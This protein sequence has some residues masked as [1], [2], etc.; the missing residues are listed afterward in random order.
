LIAKLQE[1]LASPLAAIF[2][3]LLHLANGL[4]AD[5]S[6]KT[7]KVSTCYPSWGSRDQAMDELR[8]SHLHVRGQ[9]LE[10]IQDLTAASTIASPSSESNP[11]L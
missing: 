11:A 1:A 10:I 9:S 6:S 4:R 3:R 8:S 2:D 7:E 5:R